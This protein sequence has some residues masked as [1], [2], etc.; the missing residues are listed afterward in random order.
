RH[1]ITLLC[2]T[3]P[4]EEFMENTYYQ[5]IP[6]IYVPEPSVMAEVL[7]SIEA[8]G[9]IEYLPKIWSDMVIFDQTDRENLLTLILKIMINNEPIQSDL[10]AKFSN[11]AWDIWN[12][13]EDQDET[14][15]KKLNPTGKILGDIMVLLLKNKDFERACIIMN[16]LDQDQ[17]SVLGVPSFEAL[18]LFVDNC[19]E[20]KLPSGAI[21][22]IQ[23]ASDSGFEE[24][25]TLALKLNT[26]LTLDETHL[27]RLS[28]I[29]SPDILQKSN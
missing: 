27:S 20:M 25:E 24:V 18:S 2:L 6:H 29:V 28:K 8:S 10:I 14:R 22:C 5:L 16:K 19:I 21:N 15:V 23:Y 4:I 12:K 26:A 13:I 9:N 11:I 1:Y 7:R 17:Q 3:E